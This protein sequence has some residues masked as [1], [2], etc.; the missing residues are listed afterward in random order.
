M[1]I[2]QQLYEGVEVKG[3]G[4]IGLVSYIRTDSVRINK[5]AHEAAIKIYATIF[6]KNM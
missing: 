2:A 1:L 4:T 5:D 6:L 3:Y